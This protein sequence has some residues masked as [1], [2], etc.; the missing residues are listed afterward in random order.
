MSRFVTGKDL[1]EAIYHIIWDAEKTLMLVS[2]FI[3]LDAYFRNLLLKHTRNPK[4]HILI[5]FGKNEGNVNKSLSKDDFDFFKQFPN[6]SVVYVANLHAKYYGN[7]K[8][9]VIT[10]QNLHDYSFD[11]NIEYGVLSEIKL[12]QNPSADKAAWEYS[13]TVANQG[14][15]VFINRPCYQKNFLSAITGKNYVKSEVLMDNTRSF[16]MGERT[17]ETTEKRLADFPD[18]I[19]FKPEKGPMPKKEMPVKEETKVIPI[20]KPVPEIGYCIRTGV[21]IPRDPSRPLCVDA[22]KE[23]KEYE[24]YDYPE[25]YCHFTGQKTYGKNSFR[26]PILNDDFENKESSR[27][28]A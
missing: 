18:D 12:F 27:G 23:W 14:I 3:R 15:P 17:P 24:N 1:N 21:E 26:H 11:N 9:G 8:K 5:V 25:K 19:D 7:E 16:Y 22:W 13:W 10:S 28:F 20:S 2:P 4:L 6:I